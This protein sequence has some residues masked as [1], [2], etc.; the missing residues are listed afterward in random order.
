MHTARA[1]RGRGVG[2]AMLDHLIGV[3]RDRGCRR[4]S[5]ETGARPAFA[6]AR[7]LYASAGFTPCDPFGDYSPSRDST[8]MM[9]WLTGPPVA[10][11]PRRP[12]GS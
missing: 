2:R 3:T 4:V 1:A 11:P 6:P 12:A 10:A 7:A 8:C 9:L 5:L